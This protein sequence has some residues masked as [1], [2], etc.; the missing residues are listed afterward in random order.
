M[1]RRRANLAAPT[2][3]ATQERPEFESQSSRVCAQ[4]GSE[5]IDGTLYSPGDGARTFPY[6]FHHG[7]EEWLI[8]VSGTP[9]L[10]T[11]DGERTLRPGDA[12]CFPSGPTGAHKVTNRTSEPVRVAMVS[13]KSATAVAVYPDSNKV[14]VWSGD[15]DVKMPVRRESAVDYYDGEV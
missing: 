4:I 2:V 1:R 14:G 9:I 10:R 5:Q 15:G 3:D 11:P 7:M 8:V 6:H 13:T 12:V